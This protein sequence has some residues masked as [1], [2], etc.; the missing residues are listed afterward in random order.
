MNVVARRT[1]KEFWIR[2][3][4]ARAPLDAWYRLCVA[5]DFDCFAD[6]KTKFRS[7]DQVKDKLVFNIGGNNFRLVCGINY[8]RRHMWIKWVGTHA[9]Y[10]KLDVSSL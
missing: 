5:A 2:H 8:R 7:V 6:V 4:E 1:L 10:S 9:E 3:A